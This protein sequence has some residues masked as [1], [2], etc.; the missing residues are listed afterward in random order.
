[1]TE[2][3]TKFGCL[4]GDADNQPV[5]RDWQS[6]PMCRG[7]QY[8]C[9][10]G[11]C[12]IDL[13]PIYLVSDWLADRLYFTRIDIFAREFMQAGDVAGLSELFDNVVGDGA[14]TH[15]EFVENYLDCDRRIVGYEN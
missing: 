11:Q 4:G 14:M 10:Q 8:L 13:V 15:L 12:L 5:F 9:I 7:T 2:Y 6:H 3:N 1:M